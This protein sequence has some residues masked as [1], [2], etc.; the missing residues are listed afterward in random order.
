MD[1]QELIWVPVELKEAWEKATSEEEQKRIFFQTIENRK[2]DIKNQI[3]CLEDELLIFKGIGLKYKT[4]LEKVYEEQSDKVSKI[5]EDFNVGDK[6]FSQAKA[7]N[8]S[9]RPVV[10]TINEINEKLSAISTYRIENMI[11]LI[12]KFNCM[13]EG[14]KKMLELLISNEKGEKK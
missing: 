10:N 11:S 2:L 3:E 1:K 4:E 5:W 7:I 13:S 9:L 12:E 14:T 8:D 6:L